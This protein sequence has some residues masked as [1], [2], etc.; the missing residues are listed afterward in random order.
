MGKIF[1]PSWDK[2]ISLA[3]YM[4]WSYIN[5]SGDK[6]FT[7]DILMIS[8]NSIVTKWNKPWIKYF[9][10]GKLYGV[11]VEE[12]ENMMWEITQEITDYLGFKFTQKKEG[13]SIIF[14]VSKKK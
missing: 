3:D 13:D 6:D 1:A 4:K 5:M 8:D 10:D 14:T 9:E 11:T 2:G 12:Y 7:M